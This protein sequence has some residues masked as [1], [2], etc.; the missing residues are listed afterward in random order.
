MPIRIVPPNYSDR[1]VRRSISEPY[2]ATLSTHLAGYSNALAQARER[3]AQVEN[4]SSLVLRCGGAVG[5]ALL[6]ERRHIL[7]SA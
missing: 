3:V 5:F 1:S 4:R 7:E 6:R 2:N